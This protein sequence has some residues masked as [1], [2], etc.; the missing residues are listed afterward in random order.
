MELLSIFTNITDW[1]KDQGVVVGIGIVA[2]ILAKNGWT[3]AIKKFSASATVI[4]KELGEFFSESSDFF[5]KLDTAIMVDG[6]IKENSV[7]ELIKEGKEVLAEGK[8]VIIS[9]KP[10]KKTGNPGS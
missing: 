1:L 6:E 10:K 4:T 9:I 2:G 5:K 3:L 8:D 7:K